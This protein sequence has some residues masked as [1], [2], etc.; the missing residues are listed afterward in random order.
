MPSYSC[1]LGLLLIPE[2]II[3]VIKEYDG[4]GINFYCTSCRL[5]VGSGSNDHNL[6]ALLLVGTRG[7]DGGASEQAVKHIYETVKR[8]CAAVE[9]WMVVP[10]SRL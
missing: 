3:N 9:V 4:R 8:M 1:Y 7:L 6:A 2:S 10:V 5:E